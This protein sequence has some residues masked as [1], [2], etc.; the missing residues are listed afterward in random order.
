MVAAFYSVSVG[1]VKLV[2]VTL[3]SQKLTPKIVTFCLPLLF[4]LL[5]TPLTACQMLPNN[6]H[7]TATPTVSSQLTGA[8]KFSEKSRIQGQYLISRISASKNPSPSKFS[9][10]YPLIDSS[11]A[12][13]S[14]SI[15]TEMAQQ[16][17]DIQ[18]YIWHNDA[19]GQL[20]LKDLYQAANRGVKVRLLLDD[21]NTNPEL[22]QQLLAFAAHANIQVRLIN[23]KVVRSFTPANFVVALPRYQRRMHNKSMTFDRQLSI[24]GGRNIGDE[25][26]RKDS[27]AE[28]A[29]L[30]VLLAGKVVNQINDS[31]EDYWDSPLSYDIERLVSAS[32]NPDRNKSDEPFLATLTA[33]APINS[34]SHLHKSSQLYRVQNGAIVDKQL[35]N[36]KIQFRWQPMQFLADDV[37]KLLNQ[38][39]KDSRLVSKLRARIGTP[40]QQL[41]IVSSYFVPTDLGVLQLSK[42]MENGVKINIFTNSYESTDVPIVHSGYNVA[43]VPMLKAGIGLYELKSSADADFRRKKRSLYR[44]KY[45]TSLHTKAFAVDDKYTFIGSYNVDPR[46]ANINTELGVLI[47]DKDLAKSFH[48]TFDNAMLNVSYRV[49]L[50]DNG[51]LIWQTHDDKTNK[52][53]ITLDKEPHMTFV[54]RLWLKIFSA[55]PFK[56]LL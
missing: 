22:D 30:D 39:D 53:L 50:N 32:K 2:L 55:L 26:L 41:T 28:F 45:S 51:Q 34:Q 9:G 27:I 14:R 15:L 44:S 20:M 48:N 18:Y 56:R 33:I 13:A 24:I 21:L 31:F 52:K 8:Q 17:I 5:L 40:K 3:A 42:L 12:F 10:Y 43:R 46:S 54:N 37:K 36:K 38:D 1:F 4:T 7:I 25:Y 49:R 47:E 16:T 19:A 35:Y 6:P 29:D 11:D 23:P